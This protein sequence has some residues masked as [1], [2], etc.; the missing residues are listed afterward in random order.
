[1]TYQ[2]HQRLNQ[3]DK[4]G[5]T[6]VPFYSVLF[7]KLQFSFFLLIVKLD[8]VLFMPH[9]RHQCPRKSIDVM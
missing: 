7:R 8:I 3:V 1:M 2:F 5:M 6:S 4:Q 9:N